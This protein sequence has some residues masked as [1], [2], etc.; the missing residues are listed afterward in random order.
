MLPKHG[1]KRPGRF[2]GMLKISSEREARDMSFFENTRRP[3]GLGGKLMVSMMNIGHKALADWGL[4]FLSAAP[5]AKILD[6]GC[7]GG[8][9]IRKLLKKYPQSIVKGEKWTE[10]IEGMT[11]YKDTELK[12]ALEQSGFRDV[13]IHKNQRG[14]LC[15]LAR[16]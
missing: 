15:V 8:A 2:T 10:R 5:D 11:I 16:K 6:C 13:Q 4:R 7:G 9:N 1:R 12:A 14:W 3:D